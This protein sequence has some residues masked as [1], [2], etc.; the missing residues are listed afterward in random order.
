[1]FGRGSG[2]VKFY[3]NWLKMT[4]IVDFFF[5]SFA[6]ISCG[7]GVRKPSAVLELSILVT[8]IT[9]GWRLQRNIGL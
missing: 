4:P 3:K 6:N 7:I 5:I 8:L 9:K 2:G 1:M